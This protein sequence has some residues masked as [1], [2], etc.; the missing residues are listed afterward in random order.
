VAFDLA[1]STFEGNSVI[2][3]DDFSL[4]SLNEAIWYVL[5]CA[6]PVDPD[7]MC[8]ATIAI[9]IANQDYAGTI[10]QAFKNPLTFSEKH[11][12]GEPI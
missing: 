9:C 11:G 12:P 10:R 6:P 5:N 2:E 8:R 4:G 1:C 7:R 3:T